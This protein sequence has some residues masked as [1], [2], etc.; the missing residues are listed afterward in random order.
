VNRTLYAFVPNVPSRNYL[1]ASEPWSIRI[2]QFMLCLFRFS[3]FIDDIS[4]AMSR[5]FPV[6]EE[7]ICKVSAEIGQAGSCKNVS[8]VHVCLPHQFDG[9]VLIDKVVHFKNRKQ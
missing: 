9:I 7:T 3:A 5:H 1:M 8:R 4:A 2:E 6:R